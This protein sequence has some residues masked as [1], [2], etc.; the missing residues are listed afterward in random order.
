MAPTYT[1][2]PLNKKCEAAKPQDLPQAWYDADTTIV[3]D[4]VAT[5]TPDYLAYLT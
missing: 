2:I 3:L 1:D 4:Q 5:L